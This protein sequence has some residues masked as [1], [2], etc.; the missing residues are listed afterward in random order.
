MAR[1]R[2]T[3]PDLQLRCL[4]VSGTGESRCRRTGRDVEPTS[5]AGL[6]NL[7]RQRQQPTRR[8]PSFSYAVVSSST[9]RVIALFQGCL[10]ACTMRPYP[11][12]VDVNVPRPLSWPTTLRPTAVRNATPCH[13]SSGFLASPYAS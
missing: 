13:N 1:L 12:R 7:R 5:T 11:R 9:I 3:N 4:A 8:Q 6:G 10:A 2:D